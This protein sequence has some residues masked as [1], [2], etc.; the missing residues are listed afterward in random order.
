MLKVVFSSKPLTSLEL[1]LWALNR[2]D[3][4][5]KVDDY[6]STIMLN[7]MILSVEHLH[8]T[9][10][11]KQTL[12]TQLQYAQDFMLKLKKS[13]KRSSNLSASYFTN[14]KASWYQPTENSICLNGVLKD[15]PKQKSSQKLRKTNNK[16]YKIVGLWPTL[17][18]SNDDRMMINAV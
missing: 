16:H 1:T 17:E 2:S 6:K 4:I 18:Q 14:H 5:T 11:I 12:T 8:A 15:L 3:Q 9:S 13:I 7:L 10:H